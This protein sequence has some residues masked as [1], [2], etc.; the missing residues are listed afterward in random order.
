MDWIYLSCIPQKFTW[1][2][3]WQSNHHLKLILVLLIPFLN[4]FP[5][6][7][8]YIILLKEAIAIREYRFNERVY[9]VCNSA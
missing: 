8:G 4:Y 9:I 7:A 2:E 5:F 1:T 6:V 3:I